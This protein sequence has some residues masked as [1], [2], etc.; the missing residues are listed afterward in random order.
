MDFHAMDLEQSVPP[1]SVIIADGA[2]NEDVVIKVSDQGG[3]IP[4]S[5]LKRIWSYLYTTASPSVQE[6]FINGSSSSTTGGRMSSEASSS[7]TPILAGLGYGLP[8]SRAYLRYFGGDLDIE[9]MEG[10]G[11]GA[12]VN[13][14]RLG[15]KAPMGI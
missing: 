8:L 14:V 5:Q 6:T 15:D 2:E 4:R 1:V 3:G 10:Y 9:S 13:L 12:Y 7:N 11:T